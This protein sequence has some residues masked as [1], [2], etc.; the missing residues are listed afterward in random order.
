M[1]VETKLIYKIFEKEMNPP[2]S[3]CFFLFNYGT[4]PTFLGV[5]SEI[6]AS[7]CLQEG[8]FKCKGCD[9]RE[10]SL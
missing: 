7:L 5:P 1:G 4:N 3:A 6:G 8:F 9:Q 2:M 10:T